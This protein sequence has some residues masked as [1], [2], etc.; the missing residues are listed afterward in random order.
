MHVLLEEEKVALFDKELGLIFDPIIREFTRL[1]LIKAPPYYFADCPASSSGKFHPLD[2]LCG[3]GTII[4][5]KR[6]FT[7]A[8]E[9]CVGFGCQNNRDLILAAC[10][11]HDLVKQGRTKTGHTVKNHPALAAELVE[12]VQEATQLLDENNYNII[13]NCVGYHYG[14]WSAA[15]W[16]KPIRE[17]TPEE[18]CVYTADYVASKKCVL[19]NYTREG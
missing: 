19:V 7:V 15:P 4:H 18:L 8:Y 13:R 5:T 17:Y 3:D 9:L 6:V 10:I 14:L 16:I 12:Q 1:C 2:E 11:I